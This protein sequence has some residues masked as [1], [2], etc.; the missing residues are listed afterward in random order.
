MKTKM[1]SILL[2]AA[3][4][5]G[6]VYNP[7]YSSANEEIE[8]QS[9]G[10]AS[11]PVGASTGNT[12]K[13]SIPA[14][15]YEYEYY[16]SARERNGFVYAD[17]TCTGDLSADRYIDVTV[18]PDTAYNEVT[19]IKESVPTTA[20]FTSSSLLALYSGTDL[21]SVKAYSMV[22]MVRTQYLTAGEWKCPLHYTIAIK[23]VP[24]ML[25]EENIMQIV[26]NDKNVTELTIP[27]KITVNG[28]EYDV[29]GI[30]AYAFKN[31]YNLTT[32]NLEKSDVSWY[33]MGM[34]WWSSLGKTEDLTINCNGNNMYLSD[35]PRSTQFHYNNT[36]N[37]MIC[38]NPFGGV[39]NSGE[40]YQAVTDFDWT[41]V[42]SFNAECPI[43]VDEYT[44]SAYIIRYD[45]GLTKA[46]KLNIPL[47]QAPC[48]LLNIQDGVE[49]IYFDN[50][51]V[52]KEC[53][54]NLTTLKKVVLGPN[55][56][57]ICED[58]FSGCTSLTDI[59]IP[60]T[61]SEISTSAFNLTPFLEKLKEN[62]EKVYIN[63]IYICEG[64]L[65]INNDSVYTVSKD[66]YNVYD[67]A[68]TTQTLLNFEAGRKDNDDPVIFNGTF[69]TITT[70]DMSN[71][72]RYQGK[73]TDSFPNLKN[74]IIGGTCI[75]INDSTFEYL[76]SLGNIELKEGLNYIGNFSFNHCDGYTKSSITIPASVNVIGSP[77]Y[78]L[79]GNGMSNHVFYD[80]G[81]DGI[82]N[83]FKVATGNEYYVAVDGVLYTKDL[84]ALVAVPKS[85]EF[86][87][88]VMT[89]PDETVNLG[90][91]SFSRN[92]S[93]KELVL[94]DCIEI[95][96]VQSELNSDPY[97]S[98]NTGNS[99]SCAV[100]EF[101][102]IEKYTV[103]DTNP[104]YTSIDGV[105]YSKDMKKLIAVP[106]SYQGALNI[107]EGVEEWCENAIWL[108]YDSGHGVNEGITSISIPSTM[109]IIDEKQ[110]AYIKSLGTNKVS[111]AAGNTVYMMYYNYGAYDNGIH[112]MS[113]WNEPETYKLT[114]KTG[115]PW[116]SGSDGRV[117]NSDDAGSSQ[118][119]QNFEF[120]SL[121][122]GTY[123]VTWD[124][125]LPVY[126]KA[127]L[128]RSNG[129]GN[130]SKTNSPN[131]TYS[132]FTTEKSYTFTVEDYMNVLTIGAGILADEN[133]TASN[134]TD[135]TNDEKAALVS[136]LTI[137][138]VE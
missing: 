124:T 3:L 58:A 61:V 108:N 21:Q 77:G 107:P 128:V 28:E 54:K 44:M 7:M 51:V 53:F 40:S 29:G 19:G 15:D 97:S 71:V 89:L 41:K 93:I 104:N 85:K 22:P 105:I 117:G 9:T 114:G 4:A 82:F 39:I 59:S 66:A 65:S 91:L 102:N 73:L 49:E 26:N 13:V 11:I 88:G 119:L 35:V 23:K 72:K 31:M 1:L 111:I 138:K 120:I 33:K 110:L 100:Y 32:L 37:V 95:H 8:M 136:A 76:E 101:T 12:F 94:G 52:Y 131:S 14:Y 56:K 126:W 62:T 67:T 86:A 60:E 70:L 75:S 116:V 5:V 90:E 81:K 42:I 132:G 25:S 57:T 50:D 118:S 17:I 24:I 125:E 99:L 130:W 135:L 79:G 92:T 34:G 80:F 63:G 48:E 36:G 121:G 123:T 133:N 30:Q 45:E 38:G 47:L 84:K 10:E 129:T 113:I 137:T 109:K 127:I 64:N 43:P 115:Y 98:L 78:L 6:I 96:S 68:I 2:L 122:A 112:I 103:K 106:H 87:D 16:K 55:V 20:S 27:A 74:V 83:E 46:K 69:S 18:S 134:R